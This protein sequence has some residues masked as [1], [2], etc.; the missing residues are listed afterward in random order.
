MK[1]VDSRKE[2]MVWAWG[3]RMKDSKQ[4][5]TK[6]PNQAWELNCLSLREQRVEVLGYPD[7]LD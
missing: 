2:L 1:A 6:E 5:L 4:V 3:F 7:D